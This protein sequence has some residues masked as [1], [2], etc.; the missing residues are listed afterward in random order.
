MISKEVPR[1]QW[2]N[3]RS[4]TAGLSEYMPDVQIVCSLWPTTRGTK[5]RDSF[6]LLWKC[7]VMEPRGLALGPAH[8]RFND[9]VGTV[10]ADDAEAVKDQPSL[11]ELAGIDRERFTILAVDVTVDSQVTAT[12]YAIDRVE[13]GIARHAEISELSE[14]R[15][16]IPVVSFDIPQPNVK[17]LIKH[18]FNRISIRMVTQTLRDHL[19]VVSD[20]VHSGTR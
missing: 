3:V 1:Q 13:L 16:D 4:T 11:Y 18:A 15:R 2:L 10:A 7:I 5:R 14:T 12:V 6:A 9:Y 20:S 17:D 8:T 19:L